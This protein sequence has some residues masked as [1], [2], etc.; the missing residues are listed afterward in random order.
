MRQNK[1]NTVLIIHGIPVTW[2]LFSPGMLLSL[3]ISAFIG[4]FAV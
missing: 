4:V 2:N 1:R 3:G